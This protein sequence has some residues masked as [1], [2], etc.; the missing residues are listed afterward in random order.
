[1]AKVWL[2]RANQKFIGIYFCILCGVS[3]CFQS[4]FFEILIKYFVTTNQ[5]VIE[6]KNYGKEFFI[7]QK[8]LELFCCVIAML[9]IWKLLKDETKE[10]EWSNKQHGERHNS[11][12]FD[13]NMASKIYMNHNQQQIM[14]KNR[15]VSYSS[16]EDERYEHSPQTAQVHLLEKKRSM[17]IHYV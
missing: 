3:H 8:S 13:G 6:E 16:S 4:L 14:K 9:A 7:V 5:V 1:M 15:I 12:I 11:Q 17:G 10:I 2:L